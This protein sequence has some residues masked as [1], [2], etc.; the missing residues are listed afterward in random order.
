[1]ATE[2]GDTPLLTPG[3]GGQTGALQRGED[4]REKIAG[5][6][7]VPYLQT[8]PPSAGPKTPERWGSAPLHAGREQGQQTLA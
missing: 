1:M 4:G 3:Q 6:P 2:E 5:A 8:K 7:D